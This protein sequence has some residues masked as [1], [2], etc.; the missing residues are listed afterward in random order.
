MNITQKLFKQGG[1]LLQKGKFKMPGNDSP[2]MLDPFGTIARNLEEQTALLKQIADDAR[3]T[4][5]ITK[6]IHW[7]ASHSRKLQNNIRLSIMGP[8]LDNVRELVEDRQ[9]SYMA[10]MEVIRDANM[11]F[12][13][14]GDGELRLM[15]QPEF[16]LRFQSN[17]PALQKALQNT[18]EGSTPGLMIGMPQLFPD[19]HW[20]TVWAEIWSQV[21]P[22]V[23]AQAQYGNSHVS[24]PVF[25]QTYRNEAVSAW[26]NLWAGKSALIVT[27]EGSRFDL[28]DPLFSCLA[29]SQTIYSKATHAFSDLPRIMDI[30]GSKDVDVVLISLGPAGT[31]LAHQLAQQGQQA[32]DIGHLSASYLHA[33]Q[34]GAFPEAMPYTQKVRS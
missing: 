12:A 23:G 31:V 7:E 28:I 16:S 18:L 3:E 6:K 22:F 17:S 21:R 29:S 11:S 24:R 32:L 13:R 4:L 27:G 5:E 14:F 30:I 10:S 2:S 33:L 9:L 20:T 34:G 26:T 8:L 19:I 15:V 25:F 1:R